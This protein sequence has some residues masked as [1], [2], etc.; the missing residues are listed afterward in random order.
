MPR[1]RDTPGLMRH[2]RR[3]LAAGSTAFVIGLAWG[4]IGQ[5]ETPPQ[6]NCSADDDCFPGAPYCDLATGRCEPC[7]VDDHC[8]LDF[9]CHQHEC[10]PRCFANTDCA[11]PEPHCSPEGVC[12]ECLED[13]HC[14][15]DEP[16][17]LTEP[18]VG[19]CVACIVDEDCSDGA[20][21]CG[22]FNNCVQCLDHADCP[23]H[24]NCSQAL[25]N[26]CVDDICEPGA[27][28]CS[29]DRH[30]VIQCDEFGSREVTAQWCPNMDCEDGA[31][32]GPAG[33]DAGT[34]EGQDDTAEETGDPGINSPGGRGC[35]C[36]VDG[37]R[38]RSLG[39]LGLVLLGL[40][41]RGFGWR[42]RRRS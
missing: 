12:L 27:L 42:A 7:L 39:G 6:S 18:G 4:S 26:T 19:E 9:I 17:C 36:D 37:E 24:Q 30:Q 31:C 35:S 3:V 8:E 20:P 40:L 22:W 28:H 38:R 25:D 29:D 33:M 16:L 41:G 2:V 14:S 32:G 21:I 10:I 5:A 11:V 23:E 15:A 34:S 13:A 1:P